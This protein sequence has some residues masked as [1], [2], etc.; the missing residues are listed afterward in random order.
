[1]AEL[2]AVP[3]EKFGLLSVEDA[4]TRRGVSDETIRVWIRNGL[5]VVVVG[6][7]RN[8]TVHL[9]PIAALDAYQPGPRGRPPAEAKP[10]AKGKGRKS[11]KK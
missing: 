8:R 9:V 10:A 5:P 2:N 4:A 7:G 3:V 11:A 6:K 1:M